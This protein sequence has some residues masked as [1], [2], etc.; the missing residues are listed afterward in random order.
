MPPPQNDHEHR[1]R[2]LEYSIREL[3][4]SLANAV[5]ELNDANKRVT[6][7]VDDNESEI[8][9]NREDLLVIKTKH[10]FAATLFG[11]LGAL[12]IAGLKLLI[13]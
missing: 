8:R 10:A 3:T 5:K 13:H 7:Q 12:G 11:A 9:K 2:E 6:N 1:I 4:L